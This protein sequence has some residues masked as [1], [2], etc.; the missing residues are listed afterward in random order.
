MKFLVVTSLGMV[1]NIGMAS[2]GFERL[3][4]AILLAL[5]AG[6]T[7]DFV[8]KYA[9]SSR[10]GGCHELEPPIGQLSALVVP[11]RGG[12]QLAAG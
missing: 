8:W 6:I 2:V 4:G 9:A 10:F 1:A 5:P 7:V 3:G 11:D 12:A